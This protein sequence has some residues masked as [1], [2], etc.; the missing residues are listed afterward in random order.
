MN[1]DD[2]VERLSRAAGFSRA[3]SRQAVDLV[4]QSVCSAA[5]RGESISIAGI[6]RFTVASAP[7][8]GSG[9][10]TRT[11]PVVVHFL[12]YWPLGAPA[13]PHVGS[14]PHPARSTGL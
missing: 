6:G 11:G 1:T 9:S 10:W 13:R 12:P 5:A 14:A 4:F 7:L 2:L 8:S 3:Q